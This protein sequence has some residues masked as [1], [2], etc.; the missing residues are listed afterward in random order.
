MSQSNSPI[1]AP[2]A[3]ALPGGPAHP[4]APAA[5][6]PA[7]VGPRE[8]RVRLGHLALAVALV[9]V[10]ALGTTF[11]VTLVA[12]EGEYLAVAQDVNYGAPINETDLVVVRMSNPQGVQP[13][14]ANELARV[15][16]NY[17]TMPLAAGTL[18]TPAHVTDRPHPGPGEVRLGVSVRSDRLPAQPVQPGNLLLLVETGGPTG[19]STEDQPAS[20]ART[21]EAIVV[22][23]GGDGSDSGLLG[24]GGGSRTV[25]LDIVVPARDAP[26]IAALAADNELSVAVMPGQPGS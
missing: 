12:A 16:G 9:V 5:P 23:V 19:D 26:V 7:P 18:L 15:V 4:G 14:P 17:A 13:V 11:L 1:S 10:G 25:T 20:S 8:R 3:P 2:T 24:G 6:I 22:G 21:W